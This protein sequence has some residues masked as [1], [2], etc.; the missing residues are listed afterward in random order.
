MA[1]LSSSEKEPHL[2]S[3]GP[4]RGTVGNGITLRPEVTGL[5]PRKSDDKLF[6]SDT[7]SRAALNLFFP[8]L[9]FS[10]LFSFAFSLPPSLPSP[11][12]SFLPSFILSLSLSFTLLLFHSICAPNSLFSLQINYRLCSQDPQPGPTLPSS[13]WCP[14]LSATYWKEEGGQLCLF[15]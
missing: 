12:V 7:R 4:P 6:Q 13:V 3:Q 8:L 11:P 14:E 9:N 5:W 2:C 10:F 1:H 15:V